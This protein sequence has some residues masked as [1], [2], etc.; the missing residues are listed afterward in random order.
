MTLTNHKSRYLIKD[1]FLLQG[2][3]GRK[4]VQ[5]ASAWATLA[6]RATKPDW[7]FLSFFCGSSSSPLSASSQDPILVKNTSFSAIL[8]VLCTSCSGNSGQSL[9]ETL[10]YG[11]KEHIHQYYKQRPTAFRPMAHM[12]GI[13]FFSIGK[14]ERTRTYVACF[15]Q[16]TS[17]LNLFS[18][19]RND[20][21][22][23]DNEK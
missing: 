13:I 20:S 2:Q 6:N 4:V 23:F 8:G 1:V 15:S 17:F 12:Q 22:H 14:M 9:G 16:T 11:T 19:L 3:E 7:A 10:S 21:A 18:H 5:T